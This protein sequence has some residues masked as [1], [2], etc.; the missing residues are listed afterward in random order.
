MF[1]LQVSLQ[2][3]RKHHLFYVLNKARASH[4]HVL[5]VEMEEAAPSILP[6]GWTLD[7]TNEEGKHNGNTPEL[8]YCSN[9]FHI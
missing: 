9:F 8:F 7:C 6:L 3:S 4:G 1:D 2:L 5:C